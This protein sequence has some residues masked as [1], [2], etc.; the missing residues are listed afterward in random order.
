MFQKKIRRKL[1]SF[2]FLISTQEYG[3]DKVNEL[4]KITALIS[5][6][7][8]NKNKDYEKIT[9]LIKNK[10]EAIAI[11][12]DSRSKMLE[13]KQKLKEQG[14]TAKVSASD[15]FY[16]TKEINDIY[17]TLK[18]IEILSSD[19]KKKN[20]KWL[21]E[22]DKYYLVGAMRSNIL[23]IDDNSINEYLKSNTIPEELQFYIKQSKILPLAE[24][25]KFIY[26]D[27]N[28]ISTYAHFDDIS[29]KVAN[30]YKFLNLCNDYQVS[31]E[32]GFE[33]FFIINRKFYL[34]Q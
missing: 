6:I 19:K 12:F 25:V 28:I 22:E 13:L 11:V 16:H 27:S 21:S 29:Q 33:Y 23:K 4:D 17:N 5:D 34:F 1:G 20:L 14:I 32:S 2:K 24:L 10:E 26:D 18:A 15:N 8:Y 30:L 31:P 9:E 7:Y 3:E